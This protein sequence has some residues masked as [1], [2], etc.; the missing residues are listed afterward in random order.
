[1][2]VLDRFYNKIIIQ[3]N[4]CHIFDGALSSSGHCM[5]FIK[6]PNIT[7]GAH[8]FAWILY[9]KRF[10]IEDIHHK[11]ENKK[12][13]NPDHLEE[14]NRSS[15]MKIHH[16]YCKYGHDLSIVGQNKSGAC[17]LCVKEYNKN[18]VR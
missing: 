7:I 12:C 6:G 18:Y 1:M 9:N 11:C 2:T 10:P 14:L 8:V 16:K 17:K 15:H 5:F 13:V 3:S 4:G